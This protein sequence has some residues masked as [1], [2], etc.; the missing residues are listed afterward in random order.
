MY[1]WQ[2]A[3]N[4][5]RPRAKNCQKKLSFLSI[6][7]AC[8]VPSCGSAQPILGPG[9]PAG[10]AVWAARPRGQHEGE[11]EVGPSAAHAGL[12]ENIL[13]SFVCGELCL[14]VTGR[15]FSHQVEFITHVKAYS[16][17]KEES[18]WTHQDTFG[19]TIF[20]QD[21]CFLFETTEDLHRRTLC[22]GASF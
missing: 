10:P 20:Q 22:L 13:L 2:V 9:G 14:V 3:V 12:Q 19:Q 15:E 17:M 21:F 8:C 1:K 5:V 18:R 4:L 6:F 7:S 11:T 16:S